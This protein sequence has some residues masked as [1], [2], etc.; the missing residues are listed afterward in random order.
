MR[1]KLNLVTNYDFPSGRLKG[2]TIGGG[3]RYTSQPIIGY[4][5][6]GTA[7]A[8]IRTVY[9]GSEQVFVDVNAAYRRKVEVMGKSVLWSL[10]TNINNVLNND[11]FVRLTQ[12]SDGSLVSYRFNSPLEWVVTTKFSF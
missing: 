4:A 3:V 11:S 8:I 2:F 10:Q 12:A 9:Y 6:T 1:N 5:A 7:S